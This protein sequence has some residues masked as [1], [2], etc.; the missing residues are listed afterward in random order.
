MSRKRTLFL[1]ASFSLVSLVVH[2]FL[3]FSIKPDLM[4]LNSLIH[5][6]Y[7][8]SAVLNESEDS[9]AYLQFN[10]GISFATRADSKTGINADVVMQ[11][12]VSEYTDSVY[13]NT[14]KMQENEVAISKGIAE[15]YGLK[16]DDKIFSKNVVDGNVREYCIAHMLPDITSVRVQKGQSLTD[17][18]IVLGYDENYADN[19][20]HGMLLFTNVDINVLAE[21]SAGTL[22]GIVYRDDEVQSVCKR[23]VPYYILLMAMIIAITI[24]LVIILERAI[25]HN[26]KRFIMLGFDKKGLDRSF[27]SY[28]FGSGAAFIAI[29][30]II[31]ISVFGIIGLNTVTWV[32]LLSDVF[33]EC[34]TLLI[35]EAVIKKQLW[36]R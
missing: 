27:F 6:D 23:I 17:G 36:R 13:W 10:A 8:Y 15:A 4:Q 33:A 11:T 16:V 20:S 32:L 24:V 35:A 5:S 28:I 25:A 3:A 31:S 2:L 1:I 7:L 19:V 12:E 29:S 9:N 21:K 14:E 18:V 34:I 26:F 22:T 30:L